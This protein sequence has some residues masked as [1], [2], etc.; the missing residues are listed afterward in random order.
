[1]RDKWILI[2]FLTVTL[3]IALF[4]S[5]CSEDVVKDF[6]VGVTFCGYTSAESKLLIDR[7]KDYTNLF[8]VLSGP[9]SYNETALTEICEYAVNAGLHLIVFFGDL[10]SRVLKVKNL[11]WRLSW[12]KM[13]KQRWGDQFLGVYYYDE[14]GGIFIDYKWNEL[15]PFTRNLTLNLSYDVAANSYVNLFHADD[16]FKFLEANSIDVF[17]SDYALYWFDYLAGYDVVLAQIGWNHTFARDIALIRGAATM[18]NKKWGIIITW[19]YM[20]PPYLDSAESIYKQMLDA[21]KCGAKY[22]LIFNYADDVKSPYGIMTDEHFEALKRFWQDVVK[23][24][25]IIHG[26]IK[27]EAAMVLPRNYGWGMR[28]PD[29]KIW[30]WWGPDEKSQQIW[31]LLCVLI[32]KY[33]LHLDIIYDDQTFPINNR[34]PNIYYWNHTAPSIR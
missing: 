9:V 19:R 34:Y 33:G 16:G 10:D 17:V 15:L 7:V 29:D 6:Y 14:P 11:E 31:E 27:A 12:I 4:L 13:A 20:H 32:E 18:Q 21:Y 2:F 1:M 26:S 5:S 22:I 8:A 3:L 25:K 28:H 24:P 30:G 23:N